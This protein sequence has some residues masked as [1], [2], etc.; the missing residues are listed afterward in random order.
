MAIDRDRLRLTLVREAIADHY[1]VVSASDS[2]EALA[3]ID[4]HRPDVVL[5]DMSLEKSDIA[6][7]TMA[8][9]ACDEL[10]STPVIMIDP[11]QPMN[12]VGLRRRI[13]EAIRVTRRVYLGGGLRHRMAA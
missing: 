1:N 7:V 9:A 13:D 12:A 5:L 11:E 8:L 4:A 10:D 3:L 2:S 6:M